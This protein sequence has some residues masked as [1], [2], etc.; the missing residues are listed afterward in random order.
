MENELAESKKFKRQIK[1]V[2]IGL[3]V[4]EFIALA[5][6]VFRYMQK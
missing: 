5:F 3:S 1:W 2:L 6:A 4:V